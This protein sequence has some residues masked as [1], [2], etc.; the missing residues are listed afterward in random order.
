MLKKFGTMSWEFKKDSG[1]RIK[2][3]M[4]RHIFFSS[5]LVFKIDVEELF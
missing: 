1:I 3:P 4:L 2:F 5:E